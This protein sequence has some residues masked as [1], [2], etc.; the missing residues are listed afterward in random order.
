MQ[1]IITYSSKIIIH[2]KQSKDYLIN[3]F[4]IKDVAKIYYVPHPNYIGVYGDPVFPCRQNNKLHLLFL[5]AVKPYKNIELLIDVVRLFPQT[6][7]LTIAGN[8]KRSKYKEKLEKYVNNDLNIRLNLEFIR[9]DKIA[10]YIAHCD[11]TIF[12]YDIS[13]SL[14]SGSVFLS[15]SY[16]KSVICPMIAT[17]SDLPVFDYIL[18]YDYKTREEHFIQLSEKLGEAIE[19][20]NTNPAIFEQW[21]Q[22]MKEYVKT[23]N[24]KFL[25]VDSLLSVYESI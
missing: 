12:P 24:S 17:I 22:T 18:A 10:D 9:D 4:N 6:V 14:N 11:L 16:G 20:W 2:S 23:N 7:E 19:L 15:F 3:N 25:T 13:S 8:A 5:G 21:G 1:K